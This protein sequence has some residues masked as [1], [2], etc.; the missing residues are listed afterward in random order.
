MISCDSTRVN[1]VEMQTKYFQEFIFTDVILP[2]FFRGNIDNEVS[3]VYSKMANTKRLF[4]IDIG[5]RNCRIGEWSKDPYQIAKDGV[6]SIINNDSG[7]S[8]SRFVF[9]VDGSIICRSVMLFHNKET[10]ACDHVGT[11]VWERYIVHCVDRY[12]S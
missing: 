9:W 1:T 6:S 11:K 7:K 8:V 12:Q 3:Q 10:F 5:S 4:G 2:L